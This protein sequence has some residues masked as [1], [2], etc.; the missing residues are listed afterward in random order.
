MVK[1]YIVGGN[2]FSSKEDAELF[3][4]KSQLKWISHQKK[5]LEDMISGKIK[6]KMKSKDGIYEIHYSKRL[7]EREYSI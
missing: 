7:E 1:E 6:N 3:I 2:S 5:Q 4:L